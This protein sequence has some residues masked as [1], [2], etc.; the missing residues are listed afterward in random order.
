MPR[1]APAPF[2]LGFRAVP[3]GRFPPLRSRHGSGWLV[4]RPSL[5]VARNI[6]KVRHLF[7]AL[8]N[9]WY[10]I[11]ALINHRKGLCM[12]K[13]ITQP[14]VLRKWHRAKVDALW[15]S[16]MMMSAAMHDTPLARRAGRMAQCGRDIEFIYD[17]ATGISRV[18]HASL[19]RDR[20]CPICSWRLSLKRNN[21]MQQTISHLLEQ[22]PYKG[23]MLTLTV[24]NCT[25]NDLNSTIKHLCQSY[26][27]LCKH[28]AWKR[29]IKGTARSIEVTYSPKTDTF[30]PHIHVLLLV[31]E[32]YR[33]NIS[34]QEFAAM[35]RTAAQLDYNP[36]VDVRYTYQ[37]AEAEAEDTD[38]DI[39]AEAIMQSDELAAMRD[40][41]T[42]AV[43]YAFKPSALRRILADE[44]LDSIAAQ[45]KSHRL[46][47]YGG[48]IK[49]AR[50]ELLFVDE[51]KQL[52]NEKEDMP[53][54]EAGSS[55][56]HRLAYRWAEQTQEYLLASD[57]VIN[58]V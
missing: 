24:R 18:K 45:L 47:S 26:T 30:H 42:E 1:S 15:A 16:K 37:K 57:E 55:E 53:I 17:P 22:R 44:Q 19:C 14:E 7:D 50:A 10:N 56:L 32:N 4:G 41:I 20:L 25:R 2:G 43:K 52:E 34:Q 3:S 39:D 51:D 29:N 23:V 48:D 46:I 31:D 54:P 38:D 21:E 8:P 27:R 28:R 35:W 49:K 33:C 13:S 58:H 12:S 11:V 9:L 5:T 6:K 40:G 36:I